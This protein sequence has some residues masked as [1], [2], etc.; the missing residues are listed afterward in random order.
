MLGGKVIDRKDFGGKARA[1]NFVQA[2]SKLA[3]QLNNSPELARQFGME[4]GGIT[5][6]DIEKYRER[7][8]FT[9]HELN[10]VKTI[11]LVPTI[12]NGKF[13][14]LGGV[15]EI[16]TGAFEPGRFANKRG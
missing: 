2:D 14:H 9:W 15:G 3:D 16:N 13:G 7:N 6:K 8:K 4:S 5:A 1:Y 10:D 12:I 11:Q